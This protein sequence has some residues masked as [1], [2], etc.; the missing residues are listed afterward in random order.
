MLVWRRGNCGRGGVWERTLVYT[1]D[2]HKSDSEASFQLFV[3]DI[4][5]SFADKN[6][7]RLE[8]K[9]NTSLENITNWLKANKL[10]LNIDKSQLLF[11]DLSPSTNK[12]DALNIQINSQKLEQSKSI[13]YLGVVIDNKLNWK[14][15]IEYINHKVNIGIGIV[16]KL[17]YY[18]QEETLINHYRALIKP[19]IDYGILAWSSANRTNL[20]TIERTMNKAI[21]LMGFKKNLIQ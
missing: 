7:R 18:V 9:I 8:A 19:H 13:R 5:L 1:N 4:S 3:D 2:I 21:R 17:R 12:A 16:K 15:H 6:I 14:S 20:K 10:T 11:F